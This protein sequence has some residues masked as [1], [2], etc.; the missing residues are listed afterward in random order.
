MEVELQGL[1]ERNDRSLPNVKEPGVA[2]SE[3]DLWVAWYKER[4]G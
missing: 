3:P 1:K 2:I 4:A